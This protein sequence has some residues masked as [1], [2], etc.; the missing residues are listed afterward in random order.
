MKWEFPNLK[1]RLQKKVKNVLLGISASMQENR[2]QLF[3]SEGKFNG[4]PGWAPL[5]FRSG[6]ILSKRGTLRK[7]IAP[8]SKNGQAGPNGIV[9]FTQ[10]SVMIGS[11]LF[12]AAMM[13]WGTTK[14]P[15]GKLVPKKAQAL[16]IPTGGKGK[17]KFIFRKSVKIPARHF[18][19]WNAADE[20]EL[21]ETLVN[22][23]AGYLNG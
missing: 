21:N 11:N 6:Q 20:K 3:D 1:E 13:N 8:S 2:A 9:R 5:K 4:R 17:N 16:K 23:I 12:Y 19:D 18:D 7:S 22:L 14:L 15:N 10:D